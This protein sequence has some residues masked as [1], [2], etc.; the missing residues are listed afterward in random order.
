MQFNLIDSHKVENDSYGN[1]CSWNFFFFFLNHPISGDRIGLQLIRIRDVVTIKTPY[2]SKIVCLVE[3][4]P[5][6]F[7]HLPNL[8][9]QLNHNRLVMLMK[10]LQT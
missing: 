5:E 4:E 7:F 8:H 3:I 1:T 2:P 10:L 9:H 6:S